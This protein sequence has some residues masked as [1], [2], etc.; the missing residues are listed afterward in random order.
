MLRL[1]R[2]DLPRP[3]RVPWYPLPPLLFLAVTGWTLTYIVLQRPTE[4]LAGT[5]VF[6]TGAAFYMVS[7]RLSS[8]N[9]E[10][11]PVT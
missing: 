9:T 5:A 2:P 1:R 3:Y 8:R 6:A 7:R 4:A 11:G 10:R